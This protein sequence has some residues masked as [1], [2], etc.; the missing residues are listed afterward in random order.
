MQTEMHYVAILANADSSFLNLQLPG[1][2]INAVS[3][4]EMVNLVMALTEEP[5]ASVVMKLCTTYPCYNYDE[6]CFF[7]ISRSF[8]DDL[9]LNEDGGVSKWGTGQAEQAKL[10]EEVVRPFIQLLRLYGE[11][12]LAIPLEFRYYVDARGRH[13]FMAQINPRTRARLTYRIEPNNLPDLKSFLEE[14]KLPFSDP[15]LELARQ[16][17]DTSYESIGAGM[18]YIT[19]MTGME[20]LFNR[21]KDQIRYTLS[22]YAAVLLGH[23]E[24][25]SVR[26]FRAMKKHYDVRS[27]IVH[28]GRA[29]G[30][31]E[32]AIK[33]LRGFLR[34]CIKTLYQIGLVKEQYCDK[35]DALGFGQGRKRIAST[36]TPRGDSLD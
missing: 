2:E 21:G 18:R 15:T 27:E 19:L 36:D 32:D 35:L 31:T 8:A 10:E 3:L 25:D 34:D 26:V 22:R 6:K 20:V 29:K 11:G 17:Y 33:D 12:N 23:T 30:A 24:D 4:D 28:T 5:Q 1:F 7:T 9:V 14:T 16:Y 13:P